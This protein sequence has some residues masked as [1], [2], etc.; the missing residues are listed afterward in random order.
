[1]GAGFSAPIGYPIGNDMN[2][3]LLI[4]DDSTLDFAPCGS[5]AAS[6][7]GTKPMFQMDGVL[8][9]HQKYFIFCKR[10]IKEYTKAH[11]D[12]FDYEHFMTL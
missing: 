4:F 6:T 5:L 12:R 11:N 10:L 9:N 3:R 8:N 1:M 2:K 7:Y